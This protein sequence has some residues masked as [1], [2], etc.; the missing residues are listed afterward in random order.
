MT[1]PAETTEAPERKKPGRK[2][3]PLL[4]ASRAYDD[5]HQRADKIRAKI[6]KVQPLIDQLAD[7]EA[8]EAAALADLHAVVAGNVPGVSVNSV[9]ADDS[10][11]ED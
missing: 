4:A 10:D 5:A 1:A 2:A 7:V 9:P 6:E 3:S 11:D 8:E